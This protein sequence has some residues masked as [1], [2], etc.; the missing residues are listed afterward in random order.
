MLVP[1]GARPGLYRMAGEGVVAVFARVEETA[2]AH[3]DCDDVESRV[4]VEA[5][6]LRV[7]LEAVYERSHNSSRPNARSTVRGVSRTAK[8]LEALLDMIYPCFTMSVCERQRRSRL[9]CR[10]SCL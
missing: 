1:L 5:T 8:R 3:L 10:P 6:G 2:A 4:V 9:L 7:K